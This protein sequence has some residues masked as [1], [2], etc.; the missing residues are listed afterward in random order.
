[1][2]FLGAA[3][4]GDCDSVFGGEF[5]AVVALVVAE[6]QDAYEGLQDGPGGRDAALFDAGVVV[7]ADGGE[8]GDFL[9]AQP[10]DAAW[11]GVGQADGAGAEFAAAGF[12][13]LAQLLEGA[14]VVIQPVCPVNAAW[15]RGRVSS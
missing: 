7:G 2:D 13:E 5:E 10:R 1:M 9:P 15:L 3:P 12:E 14:L 6:V 8:L 11:A 4:D